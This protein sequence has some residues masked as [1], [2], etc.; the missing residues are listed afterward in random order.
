MLWWGGVRAGLVTGGIVL[1]FVISG[2][3]IYALPAAIGA[4]FV[5]FADAGETVGRRWRTMLWTTTWLMLAALL[6]GVGGNFVV[7]GVL[8]IAP[9]AFVCGLAG[10][11][12]PRAGLAGVL[13]LVMF[14]VFNGAPDSERLILLNPLVVGLG[15]V[16]MTIATV[17]PHVFR[18]DAWRVAMEPVESIPRRL[19]GK[20]NL[21]NDF[22]RHGVRLAI[23]ITLATVLVDVTPYPHDYWIPMT[24]A[25]VTRPD[26]N[27][28][29]T[30]IMARIAGTIVGVVI[31]AVV[32]DTLAVTPIQ[33]GVLV[34]IATFVTIAFVWANYAIA[35]VGITFIVIGLF[36]FDG[37]PVGETITLRILATILAGVM[38][39]LGFFIWPPV[40]RQHHA[41]QA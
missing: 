39:F 2:D 41:T 32:F 33:I 6:G 8:M 7:L 40:R 9:L 35:V 27:G 21:D 29:S 3:K 23:L 26:R 30:K 25:W 16:V 17:L 22:V 4:L 24:I 38:A 15:G 1:G 5:A 31:T 20:L 11:V 10:A 13:T 19:Q 12:G 14:V 34:G 36:S 28:T 37:D 18:P